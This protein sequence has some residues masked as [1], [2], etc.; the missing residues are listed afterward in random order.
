MFFPNW[1]YGVGVGVAVG[2][3]EAVG[4]GEAVDLSDGGLTAGL[5]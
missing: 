4:A 2:V 5:G 1:R 3:G